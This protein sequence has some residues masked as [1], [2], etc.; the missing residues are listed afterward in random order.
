MRDF[1]DAG[2]ALRRSPGFALSA[3]A[4]LAVAI[5]GT[6]VIFTLADRLL[7]RK[8]ALPQPGQLVRMVSLL[9]GRPPVSYF[10]YPTFEEW[11]ARTRTLSST[12]AEADVD[13]TLAEPGG[14]RLIR[15]GVVSAD[16]FTALG[17]GAALGRVLNAGDEWAVAG[18]VPTVLSYQF[19][20]SR[21]RGDPAALGKLLRLNGQAF[22]VVGVL[23]RG[24]NGTAV[25]S[26]PAM[27]VPL[28]AGKYFG[29]NPDPQADPKKCCSWEIGGRLR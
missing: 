29:R 13:V 24:V 25:E 22:V 15:A 19:W 27:R 6:G 20:Q 23:P 11:R 28:I 14:S 17:V 9:P 3:I 1:G 21:Y 10:M 16:Y 8:L 12:F 2:R 18:E 7:L 4:L 5:G 26:G